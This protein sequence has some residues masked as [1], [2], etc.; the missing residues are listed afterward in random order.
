LANQPPDAAADAVYLPGGYPELWSGALSAAEAFAAAL[1]R[2]AADGKPV[3][4]EC[5]G[6]MVL[7]E[8]LIDAEGRTQRM[9]GLLPLATS[10]AARRLRLGYRCTTLLASGPLGDA[11]GCFRGHEFHY[12]TVIREGSA[13]R[14]M[15]V[16]DAVGA[17][18]GACGLRRG[19]VFGSFIHLVDRI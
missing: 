16:T 4:G 7:G 19:S 1:R 12:V 5:G 14:L 2:A 6:Y 10:F 8:Y 13:D 11:G 9:A 18:L 15:T 17:D 3:Y